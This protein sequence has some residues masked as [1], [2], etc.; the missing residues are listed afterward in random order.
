MFSN[1]GWENIPTMLKCLNPKLVSGKRN[2]Y[3]FISGDTF[4]GV[5]VV[6]EG[7]AGVL[8]EKPNGDRVVIHTLKAGEVFGEMLAFSQ[9][10]H[11]PYAIKAFE[12]CKILILPKARIIGEC[13]KMCPWH[14]SLVENFLKLLSQKALMLNRKVEYLSIKG[15][16]AKVSTYLYDQYLLQGSRDIQLSLNRTELADFLNVSRPS[17]SREL[18]KMREE[19]IIDF[20]LNRFHIK[21]E[22][23]LRHIFES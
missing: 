5:G 16:R 7:M 4:T 22:Q 3:L 6:L 19:G 23:A 10:T 15:I 13:P 9:L 14:R 17:M 2:N 18:G 8:S 11:W 1:L 21:N 20:H 12:P